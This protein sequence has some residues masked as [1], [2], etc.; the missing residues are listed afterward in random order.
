[1]TSTAPSFAMVLGLSPTGLYV[2]RE[3]GQAGIRVM[4]AD[5]NIQAGYYS[6][7]L[8]HGLTPIADDEPERFIAQLIE[9]AQKEGQ[10]GVLIPSSDT[11][12]ET[13][14]LYAQQLSP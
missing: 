2:I 10:R 13:F 14:V 9:I 11:Y 1:M 3:L 5:A 8:Y 7:Y 4:G 6:K 12:I